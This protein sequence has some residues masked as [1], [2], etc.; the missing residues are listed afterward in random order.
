MKDHVLNLVEKLGDGGFYSLK[1]LIMELLRNGKL[2]VS[3]LRHLQFHMTT[4]AYVSGFARLPLEGVL[5]N[6]RVY[7][8][9]SSYLFSQRFVAEAW[10]YGVEKVHRDDIMVE[11]DLKECN[12][13]RTKYVPICFAKI[14]VLLKFKKDKWKFAAYINDDNGEDGISAS[15]SEYCF[16]QYYG[17]FPRKTFR[18]VQIERAPNCVRLR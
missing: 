2:Y 4:S 18:I 6:G 8:K 3:D 13:P 15:D 17:V 14:R 5:S 11:S 1:D 12:Y 16:V 7:I 10:F 9:R